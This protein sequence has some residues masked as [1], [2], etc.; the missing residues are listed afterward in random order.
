MSQLEK[1][2]LRGLSFWLG[3]GVA[4]AQLELTQKE[5]MAKLQ[6]GSVPPVSPV[7]A[8]PRSLPHLTL[9]PAPAHKASP[10]A[11]PGTLRNPTPE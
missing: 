2:R 3:S 7:G 6:R 9:G 1:L 11:S 8:I 4:P 5:R 10:G